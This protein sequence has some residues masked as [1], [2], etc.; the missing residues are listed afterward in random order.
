M[1]KKKTLE[2]LLGTG[3]NNFGVEGKEEGTHPHLP[4]TQLAD[5]FEIRT[6]FNCFNLIIKPFLNLMDAVFM[7]FQI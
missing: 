4:L 7:C 6:T 1:E 3:V 5:L 2:K